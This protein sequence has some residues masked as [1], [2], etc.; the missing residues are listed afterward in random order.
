MMSAL[1]METSLSIPVLTQQ[2]IEV[3]RTLAWLRE[4]PDQCN[5]TVTLKDGTKTKWA[6]P[7]CFGGMNG[8]HHSA[9]ATTLAKRG[10]V[11]RFKNGRIN[12]FDSHVKGSCYYRITDAGLEALAAVNPK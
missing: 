6:T 7:L 4:R 3:L 1:S 11:E 10:L 9:T 12:H 2:Q 8:S 5:R